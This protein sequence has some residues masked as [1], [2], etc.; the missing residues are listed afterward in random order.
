LSNASIYEA[1][2]LKLVTAS[3][4][5]VSYAGGVPTNLN[6]VHFRYTKNI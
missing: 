2:F 6:L 5:V 3:D 4:T 1:A